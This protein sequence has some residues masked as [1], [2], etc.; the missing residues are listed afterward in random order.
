MPRAGVEDAEPP[1]TDGPVACAAVAPGAVAADADTPR[2][3]C[4]GCAPTGA[5]T[6][7]VRTGVIGNDGVL[8]DGVVRLG[9]LTCGVVTGPTVT[10]GTV[11]LGTVSVGTLAG[12]TA[13]VGT[14][15]V[16]TD[17]VG[18]DAAGAVAAATASTPHAM[19]IASTERLMRRAATPLEV[20]HRLTTGPSARPENY[21]P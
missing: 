12:G 1:A 18:K 16:G 10:G 21:A 5:P 8:T 20:E 2:D 13:T 14:L 15:I 19:H 7:G 11:T 6:V 17:T 9:V 4:A 3:G